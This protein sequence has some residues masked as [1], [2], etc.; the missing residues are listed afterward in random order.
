MC[1][2]SALL[3]LKEVS[4]NCVEQKVGT[5]L[6]ADGMRPSRLVLSYARE[7]NEVNREGMSFMPDSIYE[8]GDVRMLECA[9]EGPPLKTERDAVDLISA[10]ASANAGWTAV[11]VSRLDAEFFS[12]RTRLAGA[13][14]QKFVTYGK[15]IAI[16]GEIPAEFSESR[17]LTDF[18]KECNRGRQILFVT[19]REELLEHLAHT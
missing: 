1:L 14:L 4:S 12:L 8:S 18:I 9:A 6:S 10:A 13:F 17:A 7:W 2:A 3:R 19:S 11:P 15:H 16:V 5:A